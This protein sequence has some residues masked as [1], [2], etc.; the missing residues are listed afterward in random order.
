MVLVV[1]AAREVSLS[2]SPSSQS[3]PYSNDAGLASFG[4]FSY[5]LTMN[6]VD[7]VSGAIQGVLNL[8]AQAFNLVAQFFALLGTILQQLGGLFSG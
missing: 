6:I 8:V 3:P 2:K 1:R 4:L 7:I 5:T